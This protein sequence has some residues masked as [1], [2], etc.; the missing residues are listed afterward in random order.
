MYD[1]PKFT[2][3]NSIEH[4]ADFW[5]RLGSP[6]AQRKVIHVAGSNGKGS[7]CCVLNQTLL[8][9]KKRVGMFTS[10]HLT[11]IRERFLIDNALPSIAEFLQAFY[12]VQHVADEMVEAG[13]KH[14]TFFEFIYAIGMVLFEKADTEYIVLETG[15][16]GRLDATNSFPTPILCVFTS[17]SLE[18]TELLGDTIE[19]IAAEKAGIIKEKVPVVFWDDQKAVGD[20]I[21][22]RAEAM[23]CPC[24]GIAPEMV[25]ISEIKGNSIDFSLL[26][27]YD[28]SKHW[29]VIGNAF[30]QAQNAALAVSA[31]QRFED[32]TDAQISLG[33][34]RAS[35]R[36]R[37]EEVLPQVYLDGA[38]NP[39]GVAAFVQSVSQLA[40]KDPCSPLL[41]FSM[42]RDKDVSRAVRL[43][44]EESC[45]ERIAVCALPGERG[46]K[47]AEL[48]ALFQ[49]H[50]TVPV[51]VYESAC[52]AFDDLCK[53][54]KS[55]QKL[56]A[57][58]SLYFVG[59][60]LLHLKR[61]E[62]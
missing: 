60:L 42:V 47:A 15:L 21:R 13:E 37:M 30:W 55:G 51:T 50:T 40:A 31:L 23:Q 3:K 19:Q 17:I 49:E 18:H 7:V 25:K 14:P 44:T 48:K 32:I 12:A 10:P 57:T 58:G 59:E 1:L 29:R 56:F 20:V 43:L 35:W 22:Q 61:K 62:L 39:A 54:K 16:G 41:L 2:T 38:H 52:A 46:M 6:C 34:S 8:A 27:D 9:A 53:Q 5:R 28:N 24:F 4:T 45:W 36:G 11:D 26:T 33:L